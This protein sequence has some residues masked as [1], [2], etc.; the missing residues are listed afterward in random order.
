M[1]LNQL[2]YAISSSSFVWS[3]SE[4]ETEAFL[5][6]LTGPCSFTG[7][8]SFSGSTNTVDLSSFFDL[9]PRSLCIH[10]DTLPRGWRCNDIQCL[11]Y[12]IAAT[13]TPRSSS[14]INFSPSRL[15]SRETCVVWSIVSKS[16]RVDSWFHSGL[17]KA[18]CPKGTRYHGG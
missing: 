2:R 8:P 10:H 14:K 11:T 7:P 3:R 13:V 18:L 6:R 17:P 5:S 16:V 9:F 4:R 12:M 15:T 1:M